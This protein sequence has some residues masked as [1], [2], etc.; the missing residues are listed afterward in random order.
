MC[1]TCFKHTGLLK[2]PFV[3]TVNAC[4]FIWITRTCRQPVS[5]PI[6]MPEDRGKLLLERHQSLLYV[7]N[8]QEPQD[9]TAQQ[10]GCFH[11]LAYFPSATWW[12]HLNPPASPHLPPS[13]P[14]I[15][16]KSLK[17]GQH[18]QPPESTR[19]HLNSQAALSW[20]HFHQPSN[21]WPS[22]IVESLTKP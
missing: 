22:H 19:V 3:C 8:C 13:P 9:M 16:E 14:P 18:C 20:Q 12:S 7:I 17:S 10:R 4:R 2:L 11:D 5:R 1:K 15:K 21:K 6:A